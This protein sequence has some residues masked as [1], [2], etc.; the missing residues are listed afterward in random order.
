[1][2]DDVIRH[3]AALP[4]QHRLLLAVVGVL[5]IVDQLKNPPEK[6]LNSP[7]LSQQHLRSHLAQVPLPLA[8]LL[9]EYVFILYHYNALL[10][11]DLPEEPKHTLQVLA[12]SLPALRLTLHGK[13]T[14]QANLRAEQVLLHQPA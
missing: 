12:P 13:E 7:D 8:A 10:L 11:D 3:P 4:L 2:Q 14:H 6:G 5:Q 1:M 9:V